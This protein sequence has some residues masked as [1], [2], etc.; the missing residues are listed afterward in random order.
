MTITTLH[1]GVFASWRESNRIDLSPRRQDAK[2]DQKL[3][4]LL[5][6]GLH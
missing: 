6:G 1:I 5:Y 2:E 4:W 3:G